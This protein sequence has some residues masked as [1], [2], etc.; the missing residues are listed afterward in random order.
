MKADL[1]YIARRFQFF[2]DKIFGGCLTVPPMRFSHSRRGIA[3]CRLRHNDS[4]NYNVKELTFSASYDLTPQVWDD[5]IVHEMIHYFIASHSLHDTAPHGYLFK[6]FMHSINA[7]FGMNISVT[8]KLGSEDKY[9]GR[10]K[11]HI[12]FVITSS[13]NNTYII[14]MPRKIDMIVT[15]SRH[16]QADARFA[17]HEIFISSNPFFDNIP[18]CRK[19]LKMYP[20]TAATLATNLADA[21]PMT[22]RDGKLLRKAL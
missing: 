12:I 15:L 3:A 13:D 18:V 2:N 10:K 22:L 8:Y 1:D 9:I 17:C 20:T 14:S 7:K 6:G 5:I 21:I 19:N 4:D 11:I 16:L